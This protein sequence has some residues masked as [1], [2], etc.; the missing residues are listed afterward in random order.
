M[1]TTPPSYGAYVRALRES[2]GVTINDL[3]AQIGISSA[4]WSRIER[5]KE[6]PPRDELIEAA[7]RVLEA[8]LDASFVAA[9]RLPPELR[10]HLGEIVTM[11]RRSQKRK[12][13]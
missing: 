10:P 3:A 5:D 7:A 1:T 13:Y 9:G 4:Y 12:A 8:D 11:W 2:R 6:S